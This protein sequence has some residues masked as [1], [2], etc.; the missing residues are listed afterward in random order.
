[1]AV[2]LLLILL[3]LLF[4]LTRHEQ[5]KEER[6][7]REESER[8]GKC[9]NF[10]LLCKSKGI[11]DPVANPKE[12]ESLLIIGKNAGYGSDLSCCLDAFQE[13]AQI[14]RQRERERRELKKAEKAQ[15]ELK[16]AAEQ[17]RLADLVGKRKYLDPIENKLREYG[18]AVTV[19]DFL[20][21]ASVNDLIAQPKKEDWSI[22]GGFADAVAGP[23][24]ALAT[25]SEIQARNARAEHDAAERRR[26]APDNMRTAVSVKMEAEAKYNEL[27]SLRDAIARKIVDDSNPTEKYKMLVPEI[28]SRSITPSGNIKVKISVKLDGAPTLFDKPAALDGSLQIIALQN[29]KQVGTGYYSPSAFGNTHLSRVGFGKCPAKNVIIPIGQ[30]ASFDRSLPFDLEVQPYHLWVIE[31]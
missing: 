7:V 15:E 22:A 1:M 13:G 28:I 10:Y 25:V 6:R 4:I 19:G 8:E 20:L 24:A 11:K 5:K 18:A 3:I 29:G 9:L 26:R 16:T 14:K 23:G 12:R 27:K 30:D 2:F 21:D 17:K 31:I